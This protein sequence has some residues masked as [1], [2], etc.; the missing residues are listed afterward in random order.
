MY[1]DSKKFIFNHIGKCGGSSIK[2]AIH[3]HI[4]YED[5]KFIC[6]HASLKEMYEMIKENNNIPEEYFLFC[7]VRNPWDRAVSLY[8]HKKTIQRRLDDQ[9]IKNSEKSS[10][11]L[12][13]DMKFKEYL[14][15]Y[16]KNYSISQSYKKSNFIIRFENL[17]KDFNRV[18]EI[19]G[20][21][22][23]KLPI[24][25][26]STGRPKDKKYQEYYDKES[27]DLVSEVC[28][29]YIEYFNYEF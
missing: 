25:D 12:P 7:S 3:T 11:S 4:P 6:G 22:L 26:Y 20:I 5:L 24:I 15:T 14:F 29:E 10:H 17:Q 13:K 28:G 16:R 1:C 23:T 18:C 27:K 8:Y 9:N 21:P 19:I 2:H